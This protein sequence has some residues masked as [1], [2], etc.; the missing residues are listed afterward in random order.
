MR[1]IQ[2]PIAFVAGVEHA[3]AW[4]ASNDFL[5]FAIPFFA[6]AVVALAL[7]PPVRA[8][9]HRLGMEDQPGGRRINKRPL[10]RGGGVAVFAAFH[11]ALFA[12]AW[13]TG[14]FGGMFNFAWRMKFLAAS[15]ALLLIGLADDKFGLKPIVKLFGQLCV[16]ASL[17]WMGIRFSDF[18]SFDMPAWIDFP[19]TLFWFAG[20]MNAMN[21]IDGMDGL[22]S[23]LALIACLGIAG[24]LFLR[25]RTISPLAVPYLALAG[26]CLGFLRYNF[27]PSSVIL[28]DCG[29]MF[30]GLT[31]AALPLMT[32][33]RNE[34]VAS[35]CVPLMALGVPIFD[36]L[37]AIWRR[38]VR[39]VM[40]ETVGNGLAG[41]MQPDK[42]HLHHRVLKAVLD[43]KRAAWILYGV[44]AL[45]V[46]IGLCAMLAKT[47]AAGVF[48]VAFVAAIFVSVR[49]LSSVELWD[50]GRVFARLQPSRIS[51]RLRF[52]VLMAWDITSL[53]LAWMLSYVLTGTHVTLVAIRSAMFYA[54]VPSFLAIVLVKGYRRVWHNAS[55][56]EFIMLFFAV[57]I[58]P[59]ITCGIHMVFL[60]DVP[61]WQ[62]QL[63]IYAI[64]SAILV[65][66]IRHITQIRRDIQAA[67]GRNRLLGKP[68]AIPAL[69]CGAGQRFT[70]LVRDRQ[71]R[72]GNSR[73]VIV[74]LL[75]DDENLRNRFVQGHRVFG[76]IDEL[77][78]IAAEKGA[79]VIMISAEMPRARRD[80]IVETAKKLGLPVLEWAGDF[81]MLNGR[82]TLD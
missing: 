25:G 31:L 51:R 21:L 71:C 7:T 23:G 42:S 18:F 41:V 69:S 79:K 60:P 43:Q 80:F 61:G 73:V 48:M 32:A 19:L 10:P 52:F 35:L 16:A 8:T 22:A 63:F 59:V 72:L 37:L 82:Q 78:T 45:L 28:G 24:S 39:A 62:L 26:A 49:H 57:M 34:F 33:S 74:G 68:E 40:P 36:T 2:L 70:L 55:M 65:C 14:D 5:R 47:H 81:R 58:A 44:N 46:G 54:I 77:E 1:M 38:S 30:L 12:T 15:G 53:V 29:S 76:S 66:G 3:L 75:D 27:H 56:I 13:L 20:A 67:I 6:G 17:Y 64:V 11:L 9:L 4:L 50:S